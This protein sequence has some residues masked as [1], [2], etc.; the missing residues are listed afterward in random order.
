MNSTHPQKKRKRKVWEKNN[1]IIL[2]RADIHSLHTIVAWMKAD[3]RPCL[4]QEEVGDI[5]SDFPNTTDLTTPRAEKLDSFSLCTLQFPPPPSL[6]KTHTESLTSV[7]WNVGDRGR[8]W[9]CG[10][11]Q[12]SCQKNASDKHLTG[13]KLRFK[14]SSCRKNKKKGRHFNPSESATGAQIKAFSPSVCCVHSDHCQACE[15]KKNAFSAVFGKC[16]IYPQYEVFHCVGENNVSKAHI[17]SSHDNYLAVRFV[18][19]WMLKMCFPETISCLV[20]INGIQSAW[21]AVASDYP[22]LSMEMIL[23]SWNWYPLSS[24]PAF[25]CISDL[26]KYTRWIWAGLVI[27]SWSCLL[28]LFLH[29]KRL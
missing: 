19:A 4:H 21:C 15:H 27:R 14:P 26:I 1:L 29:C 25:L 3:I 11:K 17:K 2:Q 28:H 22:R 7:V 24:L 8:R 16:L 9:E 5:L 20:M 6:N 12:E 23:I 10:V 13:W 18:C